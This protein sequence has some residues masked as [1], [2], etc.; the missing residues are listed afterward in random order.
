[1]LSN[2]AAQDSMPREAQQLTPLPPAEH[3]PAPSV[4]AP[5]RAAVSIL[6]TPTLPSWR[7]TP[8]G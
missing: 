3:R 5:D 1:M 4:L 7:L 2:K 6:N 8:V